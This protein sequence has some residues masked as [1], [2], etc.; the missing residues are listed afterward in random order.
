[1]LDSYEAK[2]FNGFLYVEQDG[3]ELFF[4]SVGFADRETRRPF[5]RNTGIEIGSIVKPMSKVAL[6]KLNASGKIS[7][8]DPISKYFLDV[9]EDKKAITIK[10]LYSHRSGFQDVFGD[11]YEPMKRDALMKQMLASKLV[12]EPDSKEQYSN[13]GYSM[14][15]TIIE[16]V[17]G[18]SFERH[19]ARVEFQPLGLKRTG[20]ML[21]HWKKD[22]LMVGYRADG[23]RWGTPLDYFWFK[24]GPGWNLRGNGGLLTTFP[25]LA[26]WVRAAHS[27]QLLDS[28]SYTLFAPGLTPPNVKPN[29][30]WAS[31]GG[32]GIFDTVV[33]YNPSRRLVIV[34]A[35]SDAGFQI[36]DVLRDLAKAVFQLVDNP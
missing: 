11:D 20:Y 2:H 14:L 6:L 8:D 26:R 5:T 16:K 32:N 10:M 17:T 3:K 31:A 4:H 28:Q 29:S 36:E 27:G 35:S 13:S 23:T 24:D 33:A 19:L 9:P 22:Q 18:E 25:E 12:Y 7:L 34:A 1:V 15:A 30:V 21:P